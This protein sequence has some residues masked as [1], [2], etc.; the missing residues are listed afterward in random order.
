[1]A[2][3]AAR[4]RSVSTL[5]PE[6]AA[7]L[8]ALFAFDAPQR[9]VDLTRPLSTLAPVGGAL[10][11]HDAWF[12]HVHEAHSKPSAELAQEEHKMLLSQQHLGGTASHTSTAAAS[13]TATASSSRATLNASSAQEKEN[14]QAGPATRRANVSASTAAGDARGLQQPRATLAG[15]TVSGYYSVYERRYEGAT[16]MR[17]L[18]TG[19]ACVCGCQAS[20]EAAAKATSA[21]APA[22][23]GSAARSRATSESFAS[24][25]RAGGVGA[26]TTDT[27]RAVSSSL[28]ARGSARFMAST[29]SSRMAAA[30]TQSADE[31]RASAT[32]SATA[33]PAPRRAAS[34]SSKP[35][36][37]A[38]NDL[39]DLE[40]LL[41]RHNKK[42]K[43]THA[44]QPPQH[45]VR[46]VRTWEKQTQQSYYKL[47]P[48]D[49]VVANSEI[50]DMVRKARDES[51]SS[52]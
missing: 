15:A 2:T 50:A 5:A 38:K 43:V 31:P 8:D 27:Q 40:E 17:L 23:T 6:S 24:A 29:A 1:M 48:E 3:S 34:A 41:A 16:G 33:K 26:S 39:H 9:F 21:A 46:D 44:Y 35:S 30:A 49:R 51:G 42:F 13:A 32:R 25:R 11:P 10:P 28:H 36:G 18:L 20:I 47:S 45:S 4:R 19:N 52:A 12:D 14:R 22:A 37:A 7:A